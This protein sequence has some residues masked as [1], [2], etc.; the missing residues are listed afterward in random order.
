MTTKFIFLLILTSWFTTTQ[1]TLSFSVY[2]QTSNNPGVGSL[3][4]MYYLCNTFDICPE[5]RIHNGSGVFCGPHTYTG[6][7]PW[8][9]DYICVNPNITLVRGVEYFFVIHSNLAY[10]WCLKSAPIQD[11]ST[12]LL[13]SGDGLE[14]GACTASGTIG[15]KPLLSET[16]TIYACTDNTA[17]NLAPCSFI[18]FVNPCTDNN[19][20]VDNTIGGTEYTCICNTGRSGQHC[21]YIDPCIS[22]PCQNGGS[23]SVFNGQYYNCTCPITATGTLC[24]V[25][26]I[27]YHIPPIIFK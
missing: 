13:T 4:G 25:L 1:C 8:S 18:D 14:T 12:A 16:R 3:R 23:C 24:E 5:N 21:E 27:F 20:T 11:T 2:R 7:P 22:H 17:F 15:Y 6:I 9:L 19:G 10:Q 26:G